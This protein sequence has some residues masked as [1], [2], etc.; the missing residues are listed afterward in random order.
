MHAVFYSG[1]VKTMIKR[2]SNARPVLIRVQYFLVTSA[3]STQVVQLDSFIDDAE[4]EDAI[5]VDTLS[6]LVVMVVQRFNSICIQ[7]SSKQ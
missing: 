6:V 5:I 3:L 7:V 2:H 1:F 4:V